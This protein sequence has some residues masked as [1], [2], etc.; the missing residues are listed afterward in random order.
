MWAEFVNHFSKGGGADTGGGDGGT[1][2]TSPLE[3]AGY[4]TMRA[5]ASIKSY[6]D[7]AK[8]V[9]KTLGSKEKLPY[10][11]AS[12]VD[13]VAS[14][15]LARKIASAKGVTL[16]DEGPIPTEIDEELVA[17]TLSSAKWVS[18]L[19]MG[20]ITDPGA[21]QRVEQYVKTSN[22]K[23]VY[24][25]ENDSGRGIA[26]TP[27]RVDLAFLDRIKKQCGESALKEITKKVADD[28]T[29]PINDHR[30][31]TIE[32]LDSLLGM[33][34]A[35]ENLRDTLGEKFNSF[36]DFQKERLRKIFGKN[37]E[38]SRK[39]FAWAKQTQDEGVELQA[40]LKARH[41][42]EA[43]TD[44]KGNHYFGTPEGVR[45]ILSKVGRIGKKIR[46]LIP[47]DIKLRVGRETGGGAKADIAMGFVG[48]NAKSRAE[49]VA[50]KLKLDMVERSWEDLSGD[51]PEMA[52][53]YRELFGIQSHGTDEEGNPI[54]KEFGEPDED[55]VRQKS[56]FPPVYTIGDSMK[57]YMNFDW[58]KS[59]EQ[60]TVQKLR[61]GILGNNIPKAFHD[62]ILSELG[63]DKNGVY[64]NGV[65][66]KEV[67]SYAQSLVKIDNL[68]DNQI[69]YD[70]SS[71]M[72]N[73]K[74]VSV[75]PEDAVSQLHDQV[76]KNANYEELKDSEIL[77]VICSGDPPRLLDLSDASTRSRV[78]E[79]LSRLLITAKMHHDLAN[80]GKKERV[81][82]AVYAFSTFH[83]A[84]SL[85]EELADLREVG[86][87]TGYVLR[88]NDPIR[89]ATA[90]ILDGS[91]TPQLSNY[92]TTW[93]G[94]EG[95]KL[96]YSRQR[97][98][99]K[100]GPA[101]TRTEVKCNSS[102]MKS[103]DIKESGPEHS[104]TLLKYIKG[105][106]KLLEEL[107][108]EYSL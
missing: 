84:G 44:E 89:E 100:D 98:M 96:S 104:S 42:L 9:A 15:S 77:K 45:T 31:G 62:K 26:I 24:L 59:G 11:P 91:W 90:G 3:A 81:A 106:Q 57:A 94:P 72:K 38:L 50:K 18:D 93:K 68:L 58:Y 71:Y 101:I 49:K 92:T 8:A 55:G 10:D 83:I 35:M 105:Q 34:R 88:H 27:S 107:E 86:T 20:K 4:A 17:A 79:Q 52:E 12:Y 70:D 67:E 51:D 76:R 41:I 14:Q 48:P 40:H 87:E 102:L 39:A 37:I 75:S 21:C 56:N 82:R 36:A 13:G 97:T 19:A 64:P 54:M 63:V 80:G 61:D 53:K 108:Q 73:G 32:E 60:N 1:V 29:G 16:T 23:I 43:G 66:Q 103:H 2:P 85:H 33:S 74:P 30:G 46:G 65:T 99:S 95:K 5:L 47:A 78:K 28:A 6:L 25:H 69:P 22:T 7:N